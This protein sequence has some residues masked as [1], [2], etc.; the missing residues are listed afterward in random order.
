MD[1]R[2]GAIELPQ[3]KLELRDSYRLEGNLVRG[4]RRFTWTGK[5]PLPQCTLSVRWIVPGAKNAKPMLPGI[6]YYGNPIGASTGNDAVAVH[7][8]KP[9]DES[10]FEEHRFAAPLASIEW[11][12]DDGVARRGPAHLAVAG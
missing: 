5:E 11:N 3:G 4:V 8:G 10:F 2:V 12:E 9:G 1:H 6:C 7:T